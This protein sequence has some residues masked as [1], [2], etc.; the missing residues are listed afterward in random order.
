MRKNAYPDAEHA[1]GDAQA[2]VDA[3]LAYDR[4]PTRLMTVFEVAKLVGCH[5][6]TIRRAYWRGLLKSQ[7]FGMR[8]R[9]FY[10]ADVED[11]LG[12]GAPTQ[13]CDR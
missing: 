8:G 12:R 9:R 2:P 5:A 10:P 1:Q 13:V 11:W 6:E 4:L 7:R 3:R